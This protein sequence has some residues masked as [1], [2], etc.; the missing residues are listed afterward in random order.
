M[1]DKGR[2]FGGQ[3]SKSREE[4]RKSLR[5]VTGGKVPERTTS[6]LDN[7]NLRQDR[8]LR[9]HYLDRGYLF[10]IVAEE[11]SQYPSEDSE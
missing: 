2:F 10:G 1:I 8:F 9:E 7:D 4:V 5:V 6:W 11:D 3:P